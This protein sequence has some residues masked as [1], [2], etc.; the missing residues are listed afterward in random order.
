MLVWSGPIG[1]RRGAAIELFAILSIPGQ[2]LTEK[3]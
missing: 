1:I 2:K 3:K